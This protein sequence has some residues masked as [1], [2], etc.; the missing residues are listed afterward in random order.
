MAPWLAVLLVVRQQDVITLDLPRFL[1]EQ[2]QLHSQQM[3]LLASTPLGRSHMDYLDEVAEDALQQPYALAFNGRDGSLFVA[4]FALDH[5]VRITWSL[6]SKKKARY[7]V[8]AR[9]DSP[10]GLAY[11]ARS[12]LL[13]VSSFTADLIYAFDE[14]GN[15]IRAFGDEEH[16]DCPQGIALGPD[17]LLYAASF[18]RN[19]VVRYDPSTGTFAGDFSR[20]GPP[21]RR[22]EPVL[23][24]PEALA[25]GPYDA[26]GEA[27]LYVTNYFRNSVEIFNVSGGWAASLGA[28]ALEGPVGLSFSR[29]D[30]FQ[31]LVASYRGNCV[32]AFDAAGH[33][34]GVAA[35]RSGLAREGRRARGMLIGP[36]GLAFSPA[37]GTLFVASYVTGRLTRFNHSSLASMFEAP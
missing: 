14:E 26:D 31:V 10:V 13:F 19:A 20:G 5:V 17:G 30:P 11:D 36:S 6:E 28:G 32:H 4:S 35:G 2:H 33:Y 25:W 7:R 37:D 21:G 34:L 9:V 15:L 1:F 29:V 3:H 24:G 16:L 23:K 18:L 8:F 27:H 12:G 22:G